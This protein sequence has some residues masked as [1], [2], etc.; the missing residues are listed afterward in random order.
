MYIRRELIA[1]I[2]RLF[3]QQPECRDDKWKTI[4]TIIHNHYALSFGTNLRASA[5]IIFDIDRGFRL[6]QQ[7]IPELRARMVKA[8]A[9]GRQDR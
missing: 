9:Q 2:I 8:S 7:H 3:Q 5:K 4:E 6:I 1:Q